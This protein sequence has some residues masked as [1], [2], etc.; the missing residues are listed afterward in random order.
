[1]KKIFTRSAAFAL[2]VAVVLVSVP[3]AP[4]TAAAAVSNWQ[5]GVTIEPRSAGDFASDSFKQSVTNVKALGANYIT[6]IIPYYQSNTG[7]TDIQAGWNTP[8]DAALSSAVNYVHTQGL[9]IMLKP[10]LDV[11]T[12]DWRAFINP[13]DRNSW[14]AHY[15]TML[16]HVAD[17]GKQTGAE[18][19][20]VGSELISMSTYTSNGDNTQRWQTL[21]AGVRSRYSGL[22]TYSAN[23][24]GGDFGNEKAHIGFWG[25]L[26]YI[27]IS[28]YFNLNTSGDVSSLEN[29]WIAYNTNEIKP[30][31]DT[32]GKPV[33]FTEIG[34]RSVT[35]AHYQPWNASN[36]GNY[37]PT[38]QSNDYT[39]LFEYWNNQPYMVGVQL[40]NWSSDPGAGGAGNLDYT[41][42]NKPAQDVMKT[43]FA[44]SGNTGGQ[45]TTTT[46]GGSN[47]SFS[48]T[49]TVAPSPAT[50][51]QTATIHA[52]FSSKGNV[53][54]AIAD[55][56]VYNSSGQKTFQQF[57]GG[58]NFVATQPKTFDIPWTPS[59][60]GT[61]SIKAGIFNSD[62]STNYYWNDNAGVVTVQQGSTTGGGGTTT[63]PTTFT[64]NVWWP[65]NGASV[66]G[67]QPFKAVVDGL[68]VSQYKMYW[69]VDGDVLNEMANSPTDYPHK[70]SLVDVSGWSWKGNG[71][72]T[73]TFVSKNNSGATI[74]SKSVTI[75]VQH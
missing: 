47:T 29:A 67:V 46:G 25:S 34:Y 53:S 26:D 57:Y 73:L 65:S 23:W 62:W 13:G 43:W 6:L 21:I 45:G 54:N 69:Q 60:A 70:E 58:Q 37:D 2:I 10:H 16:N 61:Y 74:S 20:A 44:S 41:P 48:G 7:S 19:I 56:E 28:A 36:G 24:G 32:Y 3:V 52:S 49:A 15:A 14:Y 38:E 75:T 12:G 59:S 31:S 33:L 8:T 55:I 5:K 18:E 27:G 11:Y 17:L 68:D 40:W 30:L 51:N 1:M 9:H 22:L 4:Q 35:N 63:P 71:P 66:R 50:I 42:Q 39:A 64:T 72:Y